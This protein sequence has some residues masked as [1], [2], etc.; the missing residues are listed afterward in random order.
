MSPGPRSCTRTPHSSQPGADRA[1][2]EPPPFADGPRA[3][4]PEVT[5]PRR[6]LRHGGEGPVFQM[7]LRYLEQIHRQ[8]NTQ[9]QR[10]DQ[11]HPE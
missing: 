4:R 9:Q 5:A 2:L 1:A 8:G 3:P 10:Y 11:R 7:P 6:H